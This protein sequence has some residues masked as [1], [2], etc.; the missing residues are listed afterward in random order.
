MLAY[1]DN[2]GFWD[3]HGSE[4][5]AFFDYVQRQSV[6]IACERCERPVPLIPPKA[7]CASCVSALEYGAPASMKEYGSQ[8]TLLDSARPS[9]GALSSRVRQLCAGRRYCELRRK[10][11]P[12]GDLKIIASDPDLAAITKDVEAVNDA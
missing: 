11:V 10:G 5:Q 9:S 3:I 6:L 8:E 2:F 1:E 12:R 7:L 4:E